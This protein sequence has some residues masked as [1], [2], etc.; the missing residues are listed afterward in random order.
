MQ[1]VLIPAAVAGLLATMGVTHVNR[2]Q[3]DLDQMETARRE[4]PRLLAEMRGELV[5]AQGQW[6][7]AIAT[8]EADLANLRRSKAEQESALENQ[9]QEATA[10]LERDRTHIG[11]LQAALDNSKYDAEIERMTEEFHTLSAS[12]D[13]TLNPCAA[14][15]TI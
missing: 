2:M 4:T 6:S 1:K 14:P 11:E 7:E 8:L 3:R 13:S 15:A 5:T 12:M 9:L 10:Q